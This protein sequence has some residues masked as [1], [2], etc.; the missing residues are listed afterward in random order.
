MDAKVIL[1][2]HLHFE[3]VCVSDRTAVRLLIIY[4]GSVF[5]LLSK[6][7]LT[8]WGIFIQSGS[9][10]RH[11]VE[12]TRSSHFYREESDTEPQEKT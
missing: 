2:R 8:Y 7:T 12:G 6:K 11:L 3:S 4:H 1:Y 5:E 9:L 10:T